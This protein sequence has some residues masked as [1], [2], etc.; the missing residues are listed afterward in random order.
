[1]WRGIPPSID[2][3]F[4]YVDGKT[5]FFKGKYFWQ[6]DDM[7][8]TVAENRPKKIGT[9][10]MKC[11]SNNGKSVGVRDPFQPRNNYLSHSQDEESIS[12]LSRNGGL[13][14]MSGS[15]ANKVLFIECR[16][17]YIILMAIVTKLMQ[18]AAI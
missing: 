11:E 3:A 1:M 14:P 8:M 4:Q 5:Y 17:T 13:D 18:L 12:L 9:H 7:R 6:F 10:W 2:A 15:G 16:N